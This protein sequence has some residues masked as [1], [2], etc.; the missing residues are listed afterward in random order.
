MF[1]GSGDSVPY[2]RTAS[3]VYTLRRAPTGGR[4][5]TRRPAAL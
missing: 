2:V 5:E 4:I 1:L 3:F